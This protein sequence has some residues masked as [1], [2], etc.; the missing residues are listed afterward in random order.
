LCILLA[1]GAFTACNGGQDPHN[2][3]VPG[4]D[5]VTETATE[6]ATETQTAEVPQVGNELGDPVGLH[7]ATVVQILEDNLTLHFD[8]LGS[9]TAFLGSS[10]TVDEVWDLLFGEEEVDQTHGCHT[11]VGVER[12]QI[13]TQAPA[14]WGPGFTWL[15]QHISELEVPVQHP[16]RVGVGQC[17]EDAKQDRP[18]P[19]PPQC[20]GDWLEC[21]AFHQ[22]HHREGGAWWQFES[23][24]GGRQDWELL[25]K[26]AKVVDPDDGGVAQ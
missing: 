15:E 2:P 1:A 5:G 26:D 22:I 17:I 21:G 25:G 12:E 18:D 10:K 14:G 3:P 4:D 9:A 11:Q 13:G 23:G 7:H 8:G 16:S 6:T 24:I 20:T 19:R